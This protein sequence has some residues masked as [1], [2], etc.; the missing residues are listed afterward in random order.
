MIAV[1]VSPGGTGGAEVK[2]RVDAGAA[3]AVRPVDSSS[4]VIRDFELPSSFSLPVTAA[5]S[6][7]DDDGGGDDDAD[8]DDDDDDDGGGGDDD[9]DD[10]GGGGSALSFILSR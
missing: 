9:A 5:V 7:D 8:A 1:A 2:V 10:D 3:A 6:D 4:I